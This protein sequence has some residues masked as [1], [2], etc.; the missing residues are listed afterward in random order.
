MFL[1][2]VELCA[3]LER[4]M[5]S[6]WW[7]KYCCNDKGIHWMEWSK[8]CKSKFHGGLGLQR[9]HE[10]NLALLCKQGWRLLSKPKY[11]V[12]KIFKARYYRNSSFLEASSKELA[13]C[14]TKF[15]WVDFVGSATAAAL[16]GNVPSKLAQVVLYHP[17]GEVFNPHLYTHTHT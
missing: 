16:G 14:G 7:G 10:F 15:T 2:P 4:M 1:L 11:L 5:N 13:V 3:K 9:I 8:L 12:A 17:A 6:L